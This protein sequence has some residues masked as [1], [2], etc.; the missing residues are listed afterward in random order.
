MLEIIAEKKKAEKSGRR[1]G[2]LNSYG[3]YQ[4]INTCT[5]RWG[6]SSSY[7]HYTYLSYFVVLLGLT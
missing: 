2:S 5:S 4:D 1:R 7:V 6:P 3:S